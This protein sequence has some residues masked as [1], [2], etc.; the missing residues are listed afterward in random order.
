MEVFGIEKLSL[1][2]LD[3]LGAGQGLAFWA[4]PVAAA[5][6]S[7][8]LILALVTLFDMAAQGGGATALDGAHDA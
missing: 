5:V 2:I 3:P 4:M 1:T 6:V 7:N 8:A